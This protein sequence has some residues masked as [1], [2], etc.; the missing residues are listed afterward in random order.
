MALPGAGAGHHP[1]RADTHCAAGRAAAPVR[2]GAGLDM[3]CS[4]LAGTW[5]A[6][7]AQGC[8][9]RVLRYW[10]CSQLQPQRA[11]PHGL[12]VP[13]PATGLLSATARSAPLNRSVFNLGGPTGRATCSA[14][15]AASRLFPSI[16]Y[17]CSHSCRLFNLGGPDRLSRAD[18]AEAVARAH[19]HDPSLVQRVPAAS[20]A[21]LG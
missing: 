19:G 20:G 2:L 12:N 13:V 21:G 10:L 9:G 4:L 15:P 14:P 5:R 7:R 6:A 1:R 11:V 18:M 3:G 16:S 8:R 17:C